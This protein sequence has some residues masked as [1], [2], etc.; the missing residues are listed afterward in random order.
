MHQLTLPVNQGVE[1]QLLR[2]A[3][4]ARQPVQVCLG[5]PGGVVLAVELV[6]VGHPV[7]AGPLAFLLG[8]VGVVAL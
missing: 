1:H 4:Q 5:R 7:G 6:V 3:P 2:R 8:C